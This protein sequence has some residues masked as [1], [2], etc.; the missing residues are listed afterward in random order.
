[1]QKTEGQS[2]SICVYQ[3]FHCPEH[4][5]LSRAISNNY[6][7]DGL[8]DGVGFEPTRGCTPLPVFKTGAFN[9]SATRPQGRRFR[10]RAT[11][12]S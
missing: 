7:C 3:W 9:H 1:M 8:A 4:G 6:M 11:G 5:A 10:L 2:E 12:S